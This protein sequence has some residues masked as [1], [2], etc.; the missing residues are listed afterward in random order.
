MSLSCLTSWLCR[1]STSKAAAVS[2]FLHASVLAIMAGAGPLLRDDDVEFAGSRRIVQL[3]LN[4]S[5]P[6]PEPLLPV[7]EQPELAEPV[8]IMPQAATIEQHHLVETPTTSIRF[9]V[10]MPVETSPL[11]ALAAAPATTIKAPPQDTPVVAANPP[12]SPPIE[13]SPTAVRPPSALSVASPP[14]L[15][16]GTDEQRA[17][18]FAGNRPPS[19]PEIAR[20]NG[21]EGT[22]LLRL[23]IDAS[24][25]VLDVVVRETSGYPVLDAEAVNAVR[26][27]KG[28]PARRAGHAVPTEEF[29][30]IRFRL[31]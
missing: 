27:W 6:S 14:P 10:D 22:V 18:S 3:E 11:G 1:A 26:S 19:Y 21:W 24:G 13:R 5:E 17:P 4:Y 20:R 7:F 29:L 31:R 15:P 9:P 28:E 12:S 30:P 2:A 25:R 23:K 8:V 16:L